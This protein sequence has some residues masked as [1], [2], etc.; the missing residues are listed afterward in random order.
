MTHDILGWGGGE[1]YYTK[2]MNTS[3]PRTIL[4]D[5]KKEM[6]RAPL[7]KLKTVHILRVCAKC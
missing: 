7:T 4:I 3:T 6:C 1:K 2:S 5:V